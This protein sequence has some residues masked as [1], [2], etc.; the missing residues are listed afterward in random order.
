M[1]YANNV[2]E[3]FN[4]LAFQIVMIYKCRES[5]FEETFQIERI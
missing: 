4:V 3:Y 5:L 2:L 1:N